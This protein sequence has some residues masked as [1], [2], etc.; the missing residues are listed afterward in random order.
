MTET[1]L[2]GTG[3]VK[4]SMRIA[5]FQ[6]FILKPLEEKAFVRAKATDSVSSERHGNNNMT[7]DANGDVS[8]GAPTT[9]FKCC[10]SVNERRTQ[11]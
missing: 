2:I 8:A 10:I 3:T 4:L 6:Q 7:D 1:D 5:D 9:L 11:K